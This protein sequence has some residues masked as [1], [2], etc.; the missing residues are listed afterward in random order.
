MLQGLDVFLTV[1]GPKLDTVL[2][3]KTEITATNTRGGEGG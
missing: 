2:D 3:I 1:K